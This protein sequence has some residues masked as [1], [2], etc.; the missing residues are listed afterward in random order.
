MCVVVVGR[1]V[2]QGVRTSLENHNIGPPPSVNSWTPWKLGTSRNIGWP[3][4]LVWIA[5]GFSPRLRLAS[6]HCQE[7]GLIHCLIVQ[8]YGQS[9]G[10]GYFDTYVGSGHF[11]GC[12]NFKYFP[13]IPNM[14]L[15]NG[16]CWAQAYVW[17]K[18]ESTHTGGPIQWC[19]QSG[20]VRPPPPDPHTPTWDR[21]RPYYYVNKNK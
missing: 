2:G 12:K 14:F 20:L 13:D 17:R 6:R 10:G 16:R 18:N 1:G 4:S 21:E 3:L 8:P 19:I 7:T 5:Q 9:G 11:S 15:V